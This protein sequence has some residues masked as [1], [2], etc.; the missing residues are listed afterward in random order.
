MNSMDY[1]FYPETVAVIGASE[2]KNKTGHVILKNMIK[3]G[4]KGKIFPVNP[5]SKKILG[6]KCF[7]SVKDMP[8]TDL[9]VIAVP[10]VIVPRTIIDCGEKKVKAAIIVSSGFNEIGNEKTTKEL[11][12]AMKKFPEMKVLGPNCLGI[13]HIKQGID[14]LF[15]PR[16]RL[17]RPQDGRISFAS[18]SGAVGSTLID[19]AAMKGYGI[20]KFIS[21]GNALDVDVTDLIEYLDKDKETK[22]ICLYIEGLKNGRKFLETAK[23]AN[24]NTP[25]VILKGGVSEQGKKAAVSHT[26]S[27]AG[28]TRVVEAAFR[29]CHLI[30]AKSFLQLFNYARVL[31]N[32]PLTKGKKVQIIT[33]GGGYAVLTADAITE[34]GLELAKMNDK[35]LEKIRNVAPAFAELKEIIDLTGDATTEMYKTA[36]EAALKD[37]NVDMILV[38]VLFPPPKIDEKIIEIISEFHKKQLKPLIVVSASGKYTE[39]QKILMEKEFVPT[40]S[41]PKGAARA[42]K[43]LYDYSLFKGKAKR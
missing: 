9:A 22:V 8:E 15:L 28:E 38:I 4:F 13:T 7:N 1:F 26:G 42:L 2:E 11:F 18:Q 41:F 20:N 36:I 19:Y 10:A 24:K 30:Q 43:A 34:N 5:H 14:T 25:I 17:E 3:A 16:E 35:S 40:F 32:E 23:K 21:F 31:A 29:Q 39:K 6:L 12:N 33:D 37:K 27:I